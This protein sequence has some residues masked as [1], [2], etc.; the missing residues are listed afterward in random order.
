MTKIEW[1][2]GAISILVHCDPF[3]T[4]G[5]VGALNRWAIQ[6]ATIPGNSPLAIGVEPPFGIRLLHPV[7][8][9]NQPVALAYSGG[10]PTFTAPNGA[11]LAAFAHPVPFP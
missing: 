2:P 4:V 9:S 3:P 11:S 7:L 10:D 8:G 6:Y 1:L 5:P